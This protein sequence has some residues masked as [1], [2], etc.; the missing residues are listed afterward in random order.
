[1]RPSS[2]SSETASARI[3]RSDNSLKFF[4]MQSPSVLPIHRRI[5]RAHLLRQRP[6]RFNLHQFALAD[7]R[8]PGRGL[9][10]LAAAFRQLR[11]EGEDAA[12][13][14]L[15]GMNRAP[16]RAQKPALPPPRYAQAAQIL[17]PVNV[18]RFE[19]RGRHPQEFSGARD[20]VPGPINESLVLAT[21]RATWLAFE[22]HLCHCTRSAIIRLAA[23]A[24]CRAVTLISYW[25]GAG[26]MLLMKGMAPVW[27]GGGRSGEALE[28]GY[29]S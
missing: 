11:P 25:P 1:M 3:S 24:P 20:I 6:R 17:R 10:P 2:S 22:A 16:I 27:S 19:C 21:G 12:L 23:D 28:T 14:G 7:T 9:A 15:C 5:G 29:P 8:T 18:A 13:R 26:E 4:A